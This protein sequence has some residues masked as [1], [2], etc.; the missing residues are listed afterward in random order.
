MPHLPPP[1][2]GGREPSPRRR[3]AGYGV[4]NVGAMNIALIL[5][6]ITG[7]LVVTLTTAL[8]AKKTNERFRARRAARAAAHAS[9]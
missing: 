5:L 1:R 2:D 4:R 7:P 9:H 3:R 8:T 6:M